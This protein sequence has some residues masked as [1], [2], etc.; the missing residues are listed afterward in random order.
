MTATHVLMTLVVMLLA[1]CGDRNKIAAKD[2]K[3]DEFATTHW[4][5]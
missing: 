3:K 2:G 5:I 1:R 4:R